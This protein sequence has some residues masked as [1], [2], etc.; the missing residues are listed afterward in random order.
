VASV[1]LLAGYEFEWVLPG[2]GERAHFPPGRM[3]QELARL[4]AAL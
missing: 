3:K 2:H 4:V 1:K